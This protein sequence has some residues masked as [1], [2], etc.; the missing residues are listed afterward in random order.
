M[1]D[2]GAWVAAISELLEERSAAST[3]WS[4][5][6]AASLAQS[7]RFSWREHARQMTELYRDLIPHL[8]ARA[9]TDRGLTMSALRVLHLGKYYPPDRGGIETV[10]ETLCHGER[11]EVE[12]HALVLNKVNRTTEEIVD[13]VPVRRV[14]SVATI[15]A[16]SVAPSLPMWLARAEA[17][18]IVLHEPNPMA[19]L[20]YALAR[21]AAPLIV[22]IHSEVI[23]PKLQYRLFYEPLLEFALGRAQRIVVASPPMLQIP[24]LARYQRKCTVIPYGLEP[25]ALSASRAI[26]RRV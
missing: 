2:V 20:A 1:G 18:V 6:R 15:G 4:E 25:L 12:S 13:G 3:D 5:R 22:W 11:A 8:R 16:V 14:A 26:P 9:A 17:D 7:R 23:R 10:V 21:P 24:A 19:L